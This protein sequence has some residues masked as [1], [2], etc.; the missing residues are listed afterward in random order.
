[1]N[2][3]K[4][5]EGL[6]ILSGEYKSAFDIY[7]RKDFTEDLEQIRQEFKTAFEEYGQK[8]LHKIT[9]NQQNLKLNTN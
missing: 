6:N 8:I 9:E 7:A 5:L 4:V 2:L 3:Q 1:M